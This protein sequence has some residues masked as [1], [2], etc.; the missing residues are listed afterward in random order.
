[1][2][3]FCLT[4]FHILTSFFMLSFPPY[5]SAELTCSWVDV[6]GCR[7]LISSYWFSVFL[8][9]TAILKAILEF[10]FSL[11]IAPLMQFYSGLKVNMQKY[12][13]VCKTTCPH[14]ASNTTD[15]TS[16]LRTVSKSIVGQRTAVMPAQFEALNQE[17]RWM[18]VDGTD[19]SPMTASMRHH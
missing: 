10:F 7:L 12:M 2:L 6:T 18:N 5:Y 9:G 1:M 8:V 15:I 19:T 4:R 16:N 13:F 11:L 17:A 3:N 14:H